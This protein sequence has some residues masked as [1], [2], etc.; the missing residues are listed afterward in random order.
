MGTTTMTDKSGLQ[1]IG[2]LFGSVTAMVMLVTTI[3]VQHAI[4]SG[5]L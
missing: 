5:G 1:T 2:Y 3:L 4:A